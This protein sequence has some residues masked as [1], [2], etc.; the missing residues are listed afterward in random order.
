MDDLDDEDMAKMDKALA[1]VFRT[2]SKKKGSKQTKKE[3]R[4]NLAMTHFRIR[5]LDMIDVYLSHNPPMSHV[6]MLINPILDTLESCLKA[7][8]ND[9]K[10]LENRLKGSLKKLTNIKKPNVDPDLTPDDLVTSLQ[11]L[12]DRTNVASP[13]IQQLSQPIPLY[14]QICTLILRCSQSIDKPGLTSK[15]QEIYRKALDDF[16][17]R[18]HC[19]LPMPFFLLPIQGNWKGAWDLADRL[20]SSGFDAKT[21]QFRKTQALSLLSALFHNQTQM[22]N[23]E[24]G[25]RTKVVKNLEEKVISE[26]KGFSEE[27]VKPRYLCELLSVLHGMKTSGVDNVD[28]KR[29]TEALEDLR[30]KVPRYDTDS[31]RGNQFCYYITNV[32]QRFAKK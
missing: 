28:W 32:N 5:A 3:N 24:P 23:A 11:G 30:T 18:S 31:D 12:V 17:N 15:V 10:P 14:A 27:E 29:A 2:L 26:L 21:R 25:M 22:S 16:F 4:D 9:L 6:L 13:L 7:K 1:E 20:I 19:L 8:G